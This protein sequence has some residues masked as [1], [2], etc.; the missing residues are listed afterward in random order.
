MSS[1]SKAAVFFLVEIMKIPKPLS[2]VLILSNLLPNVF[3]SC[4][5]LLIFA[6]LEALSRYF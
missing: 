1:I 6:C 3:S 5:E 4:S 2:T